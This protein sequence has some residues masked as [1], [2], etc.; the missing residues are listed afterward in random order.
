MM[1]V[2]F[3]AD[4]IVVGAGVVGLA[5]AAALA[6]AGR[7]VTAVDAETQIGTGISSRNS[8]V[9]HAGIYYPP[10]SL[11]AELCIAGRDLLYDVLARHQVPHRKC[12]KLVV[13]TE[14]SQIADLERIAANARACG[15]ASLA[16]LTRAEARRLEPELQCVAALHSPET[17]ILDTHAF[18]TALL[19]EFDAAGGVLALGNA[20]TGWRDAGA[21]FALQLAGPDASEVRCRLLVLATGLH[22]I[23]YTG[24][25]P[26]IAAAITPYRFAKGDYLSYSGASP[27]RHHIYPLPARGG[28]GVH[29][30]I[31]LDNRVKFGP[32]VTWLDTTDPAE[33]DYSVD[34]AKRDAFA[35]VIRAYWPGIDPDR[36]TPDYSGVR[37][38]LHAEG[39]PA[40][41]FQILTATNHGLPGLAYLR[42]IE[43]PGLTAALA[44]G[45]R[46][47]S[48]LAQSA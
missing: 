35:E 39:E 23:S 20:V 5:C 40:A 41:D 33:L 38:K 26:R 1:S 11:K 32:D 45:E 36:L 2:S 34:P 31:G 24:T 10:G 47:S 29:A 25:A 22:T 30:T 19:A 4:T 27:F 9:I 6:R 8:E 12:G 7:A 42:G 15:V 44:I 16:M 21:R 43:S 14:D 17:G 18:M 3:D 48:M 46:V 13:A 37:P 28:L